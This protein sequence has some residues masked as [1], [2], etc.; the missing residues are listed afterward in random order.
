V[1]KII[2]SLFKLFQE[3]EIGEKEFN[4][5]KTLK[6][7]TTC[8]RLIPAERCYFPDQYKTRLLLDDYLKTNEEKFVSFDY[9]TSDSCRTENKDL[10]EW[11]R[12]LGMLGVQE[13][14]CPVEFQQKLLTDVAI[15]CGFYRSYLSRSSPYVRHS[16][17][18]Y[19]GLKNKHVFRT[20]KK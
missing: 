6:L 11:R 19:S 5:L 14:I 12:F 16:V 15:E 20:Y 7:L 13:E 9:V 17:E 10:G 18:A 4:Q 3:N 8:G 1:L 2:K